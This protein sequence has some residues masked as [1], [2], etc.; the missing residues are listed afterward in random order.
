M[1]YH[2]VWF[3]LILPWILVVVGSVFRLRYRDSR[4]VRF[5]ALGAVMIVILSTVM[6]IVTNPQWGLDPDGLQNLTYQ[7]D[8]AETGFFWIGIIVFFLGYFLERHPDLPSEPWPFI[9]KRIALIII[10]AAGV[11]AIPANRML[12]MPWEGLPWSVARLTFTLG[13]YPF[14]LGYV[15]YSIFRATRKKKAN[16]EGTDVTL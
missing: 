3:F 4:P 2:L 8:R 14:S 12:E 16:T 13:F 10:L 6:F 7:F 5:Q 15:A 11:A 1:I 9:G